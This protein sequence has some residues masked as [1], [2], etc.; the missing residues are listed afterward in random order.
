VTGSP[1]RHLVCHVTTAH[2]AFDTR[3]FRREC[4]SLARAGFEVDLVAPHDREEVV[5]GVR[6]IPLPSP[7]SRLVRRAVWPVLAA[8]RALATAADLYHFHDPEL[9]PA[10][11]VL[12]QLTHR[13]IVWDAHE[14]YGE[15]IAHFNQLGW[16][17]ASAAA[18]RLFARYE[19]W[20]CR[21]SFAGVV[22][23]TDR[24]AERYRGL[25]VP[26]AEVGNL[27]ESDLLNGAGRNAA[28]RATPPLL[29][30]T[31]LLSEDRGILLMVEAFALVRRH[32][33][34]RLAFWGSFQ[35]QRDRLRLEA[36][37]RA[38]G[39]E[40]EATIGGPFPRDELLTRLLPTAH[41]ACVLLVEAQDYNLLGMPTR[42]T[43][44]WATGLPVITSGGSQAARMTAEAGAGLVTDN[45]PAD[46][47]RCF[48]RLLTDPAAAQAMGERGRRAV[49]ER[50][51]WNQA[52]ANLLALYREI[53]D[54]ERT[55]AAA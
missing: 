54:A 15:T 26:V 51:N 4:R 46:L 23:I 27:V 35:D 9:M 34:C 38:R 10:M 30:T 8:R 44:Y 52:F 21:R 14:V 24:M 22:T 3:I 36:L 17:P 48:E 29:I 49:A 55:P 7:A 1:G 40:S 11:Q 28:P 43:E 16:R 53:L 20:A 32:V 5:D 45:T 18:A 6:L 47:A 2:P 19:L 12:R 13:P 39:L 50:Y 42:L 33:A 41:A 31:G 37:I 25:R